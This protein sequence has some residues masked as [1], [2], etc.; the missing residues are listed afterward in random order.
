M[1]RLDLEGT[2]W[3][4][5]KEIAT[6]TKRT[7]WGATPDRNPASVTQRTAVSR[8]APRWCKKVDRLLAYQRSNRCCGSKMFM[9]PPR[10]PNEVRLRTVSESFAPKGYAKEPLKSLRGGDRH[11]HPIGHA[12]PLAADHEQF[13]SESS[14]KVRYIGHVLKVPRTETSGPRFSNLLKSI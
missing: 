14:L 5:P 13:C 7:L 4:Y 8:A 2:D 1:D 10:V 11:G 6:A 9:I 3:T 12:R